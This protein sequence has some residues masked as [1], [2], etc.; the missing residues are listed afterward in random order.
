MA[1][2]K[3]LGSTAGRWVRGLVGL[4]LIIT[5]IALGGWWIALSLMGAVFLTAGVADICPLGP[6]KGYSMKG[7]KFRSQTGVK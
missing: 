2:I 5:G 6:I 4:A 3:F 7:K 1:I